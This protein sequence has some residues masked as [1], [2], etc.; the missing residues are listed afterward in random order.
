[1]YEQFDG[2]PGQGLIHLHWP[3]SQHDCYEIEIFQ[4]VEYCQKYLFKH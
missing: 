4:H 3:L 1:M 2:R